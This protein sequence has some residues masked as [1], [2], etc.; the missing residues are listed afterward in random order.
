MV[1]LA[2]V[3]SA[4]FSSRAERKQRQEDAQADRR[5]ER[6]T[7]HR[8]RLFE[9]QADAYIDLLILLKEYSD[10]MG[11]AHSALDDMS[12][13]ALLPDPSS[14][15]AR[16]RRSEKVGP[17]DARVAAYGS[18]EAAALMDD[19]LQEAHRFHVALRRYKAMKV[20]EATGAVEGELDSSRNEVEAAWTKWGELRTALARQIQGE[21]R[22]P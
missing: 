10:P 20:M 16:E 6:E 11:E 2:G 1:G 13:S 14:E 15:E 4:F 12:P 8:A 5:H 3:G 19:L 9:R 7:A 21:V 18:P 22:T 17:L